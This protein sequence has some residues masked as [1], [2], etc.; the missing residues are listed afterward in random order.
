MIRI[1][2]TRFFSVASVF[3]NAAKASGASA[4]ATA[5][6]AAAAAKAAPKSSCVEGTSLNLQIK[7]AGKEPVAL[8]DEEYPEW[9][10]DL[11]SPAKQ[12]QILKQDPI[13]FQR[14]E[15]RKQNIKKIKSN[16]FLSKM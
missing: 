13:K 3:Q 12:T 10:W 14:K 5:A 16:N 9:L 15:M 2:G 7:K 1:L 4:N 11:L 6:A 8:K